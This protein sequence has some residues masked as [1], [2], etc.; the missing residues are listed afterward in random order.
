[1]D[2]RYRGLRGGNVLA[3]IHRRINGIQS[4]QEAK[5]SPKALARR[6]W[7]AEELLA[8]SLRACVGQADW[9][10]LQ[11]MTATSKTTIFRSRQYAL[12]SLGLI[13]AKLDDARVALP[14]H[15]EQH[16]FSECSQRVSGRNELAKGVFGFIDGTFHKSGK[17]EDEAKQQK[18]YNGQYGI[19][20]W[21]AVYFVSVDGTIS[22]TKL[23]YAPAHDN[24]AFVELQAILYKQC[25]DGYKILGNSAFQQCRVCARSGTDNEKS[26]ASV[27]NRMKSTQHNK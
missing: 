9:A 3:D 25:D 22:W 16:H 1:M 2:V 18:Y 21:K 7:T 17:P 20:D 12:K 15:T 23:A 10:S 14:T 24:T 19:H 26:A 8:I 13:L 11:V 27:E 5:V 6:L 4:E